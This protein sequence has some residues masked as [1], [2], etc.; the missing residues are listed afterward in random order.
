MNYNDI[1]ND[2]IEKYP[3]YKSDVVNFSE[4]INTYWKNSL[5]GDPLRILLKGIDVDFILKSLIYNVET[6]KR[7]K[8][9]TKAK[10]YATVVAQFFNHIRKTTDIVNPDL[11]DAISYNRLRENSYMQQMMSYID[12]CE[13]L[14]GIVEQEPLTSTEAEKILKWAN[15]QFA[16]QEW[17]DATNFRKAMAAIGIK[18]MM[19]YGITYRELRKMKWDDYDE[20]YGCITVNDFELRLPLKLSVQLRN[21][22]EFVYKKRIVNCENLLFADFQGEAWNDIT[23]SSGIPDYMGALIGIT[24]VTS[25]VKYG[26][27]QL[28]KAGLSDSVIKKVTGASEKL[29]QGCLFHEDNEL[30]QIINAKILMADQYYEF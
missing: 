15:E 9:K 5:S 22:K 29:I 11:Y 19:L 3:D 25:A 7:Y 8:S 23:S 30:K 17:E 1:T 28:L 10:R 13:M 20:V 12:K 18:M 4:Y 2:F 27:S 21:M 16:E 26:I 24:S 6:V 14:A